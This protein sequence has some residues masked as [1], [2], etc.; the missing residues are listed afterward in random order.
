M[1]GETGDGGGDRSASRRRVLRSL[2]VTG[3]SLGASGAGTARALAGGASVQ[4]GG[5]R[6]NATIGGGSVGPT[7]VVLGGE[8]E[9]WFGLAPDAVRGARNPRLPL[10]AG[11]QYEIAWV[12]LDGLRHQLVLTGADGA[13]LAETGGAAATG[14]T[15]S[16][17]FEATPDLASYRC[18]FHPDAMQGGVA[19][20]GAAAGGDRTAGNRTDGN[21]TADGTSR[22]GTT[23]NATGGNA[24]GGNGTQ[25][26]SRR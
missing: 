5:N 17:A 10:A 16:V 12:N 1:P 26:Q 2:G 14:E 21:R 11:A 18:R 19:V 23:E 3:L 24:T 13:L 22:S 6:S 25:N 9:G 4:Q 8:R 7:T 15:R 20:E